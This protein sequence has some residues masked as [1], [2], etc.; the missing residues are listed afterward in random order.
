[1]GN[2]VFDRASA[3]FFMPVDNLWISVQ[4]FVQT[5]CKKYV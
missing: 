5:F 2:K 4:T 3:L 1:M